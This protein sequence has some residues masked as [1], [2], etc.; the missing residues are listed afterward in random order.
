MPPNIKMEAPPPPP[1]S[2]TPKLYMTP[3]LQKRK[4][5]LCPS[6]FL[7]YSTAKPLKEKPGFVH[8]PYQ[9]NSALLLQIKEKKG[10]P[11]EMMELQ[12][13]IE[14]VNRSLKTMVA[15]SAASDQKLMAGLRFKPEGC[16][17]KMEFDPSLGAENT[18]RM[19]VIC[20]AN[21]GPNG[22]TTYYVD[23]VMIPKIPVDPNPLA[24]PL[25]GFKAAKAAFDRVALIV[26]MAIVRLEFPEFP[27]GCKGKQFR[28]VYQLNA[29]VSSWNA[30][31]L[32]GI[33]FKSCVLIASNSHKIA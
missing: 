23:S 20:Q 19:E 33:N 8:K 1:G 9:T 2:D 27:E 4:D 22:N 21:G 28:E 10:Y 31:C 24:P 29:R 32:G 16:I 3:H 7:E 30:G 13:L 11:R 17:W 14:T 25:E 26:R 15:E 18:Y 12:T 6:L 5:G